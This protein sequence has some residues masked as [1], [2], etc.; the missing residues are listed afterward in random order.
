MKLYVDFTGNFPSGPEPETILLE[1][2]TWFD[3]NSQHHA[4]PGALLLPSPWGLFD[5]FGNANELTWTRDPAKNWIN[6]CGGD[7]G[8]SQSYCSLATL[9]MASPMNRGPRSG[10]RVAC[11]DPT[12]QAGFDKL[13]SKRKD[14]TRS[15]P[16]RRIF[17][18][19]VGGNVR[20]AGRPSSGCR[21]AVATGTR[22]LPPSGRAF[23]NRSMA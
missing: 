7:W 6:L 11:V 3:M 21:S 8:G 16:R 15:T 18:R 14:R 13:F 4:W 20:G 1:R 10:F 23:T 12:A 19:R 5:V 17:V 2:Y 9:Y 22:V